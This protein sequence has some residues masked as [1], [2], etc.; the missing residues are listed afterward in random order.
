[1]ITHDGTPTEVIDNE[2]MQAIYGTNVV[3]AEVTRPGEKPVRV[4]V[5]VM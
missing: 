5:P 4:C 1:V 3:V 2:C